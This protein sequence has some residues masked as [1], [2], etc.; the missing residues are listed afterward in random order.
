MVRDY[1]RQRNSRG[2]ISALPFEKEQEASRIPLDL[3][4]SNVISFTKGKSHNSPVKFLLI[5]TCELLSKFNLNIFPKICNLGDPQNNKDQHLF[6]L[7]RT[8]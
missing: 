8:I 6:F 2:I 1:G 4:L 7:K 3:Q 5:P